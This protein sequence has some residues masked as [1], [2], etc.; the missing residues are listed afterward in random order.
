MTLKYFQN[1]EISQNLVTLLLMRKNELVITS[2]TSTL[3]LTTFTNGGWLVVCSERLLSNVT[4]DQENSR[5]GIA[6]QILYIGVRRTFST[7]H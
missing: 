6:V 2:L 7:T 1:G 3:L 5:L 4:G